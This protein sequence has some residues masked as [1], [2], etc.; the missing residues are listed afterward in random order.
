MPGTTLDV[1][2]SKLAQFRAPYRFVAYDIHL[3][4]RS[5][6]ADLYGDDQP[7]RV[8]ALYESAFAWL[9]QSPMGPSKAE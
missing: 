4:G 9:G 7:E 1:D 8:Q 5:L 2:H 3:S 6:T